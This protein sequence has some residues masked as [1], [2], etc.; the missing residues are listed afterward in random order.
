MAQA[1][2]PTRRESAA[3]IGISAGLIQTPTSTPAIQGVSAYN[4]SKIALVKMLEHLSAENPDV[5]V[6]SV[7]PGIVP[8]GM[9]R[10]G[11]GHGGS[12]LW[13][14]GEPDFLYS[15]T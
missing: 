9:V 2:L 1:F 15:T 12:A 7:H 5:F 13:D 6:A 8:S 10:E 3:I 14:D 4:A 11:R